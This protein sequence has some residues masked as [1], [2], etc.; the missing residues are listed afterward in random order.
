VPTDHNGQ[1]A[2]LSWL[3]PPSAEARRP[4]HLR[5]VDRAA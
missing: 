5:A 3:E 2:I 1:Q 4:V